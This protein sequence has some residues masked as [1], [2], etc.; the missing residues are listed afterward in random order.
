MTNE[1]VKVMFSLPVVGF[2]FFFGVLV[3]EASE[4]EP[5]RFA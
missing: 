2:V 1:G 5:P 4:T 3:A